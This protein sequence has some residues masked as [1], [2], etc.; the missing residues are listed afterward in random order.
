LCGGPFGCGDAFLEGGWGKGGEDGFA[1]AV[2]EPCDGGAARE[3]VVE[4]LLLVGG[5]AEGLGDLSCFGVVAE[6]EDDLEV[7]DWI[8]G[9]RGGCGCCWRSVPYF[10]RETIGG[11]AALV[12]MQPIWNSRSNPRVGMLRRWRRRSE[13]CGR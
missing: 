11:D 7:G 4:K 5:E 10:D 13:S 6:V 9:L 3:F 1:P 8:S 2:G 12:M